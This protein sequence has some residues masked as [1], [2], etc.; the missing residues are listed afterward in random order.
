MTLLQLGGDVFLRIT[1]ILEQD[2]F[3]RLLSN[4]QIVQISFRKVGLKAIA[5]KDFFTPANNTHAVGCCF[6]G[7]YF[8]LVG[9]ADQPAYLD[10]ST[11]GVRTTEII[12]IDITLRNR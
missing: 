10:N 5:V 4:C 6:Q 2:N 8:E 7:N 1:R 11:A 3:S 12:A 9:P